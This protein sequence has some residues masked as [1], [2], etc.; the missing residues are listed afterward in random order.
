MTL[1]ENEMLKLSCDMNKTQFKQAIVMFMLVSDWSN[2]NK[3]SRVLTE[4]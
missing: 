3:I 2:S 4:G 1:L